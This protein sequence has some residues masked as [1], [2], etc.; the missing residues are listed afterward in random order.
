MIGVGPFGPGACLYRQPDA[1]LPRVFCGRTG[2]DAVHGDQARMN[3]SSPRMSKGVTHMMRRLVSLAAVLTLS[4]VLTARAADT[5]ESVEK[6][7]ADQTQKYKSLQYTMHMTGEMSMSGMTNKT[8][9]D[10]QFQALRKGGKVL[11]RMES[12]T[13]S[14]YRMADQPEQ[15]QDVTNLMVNDGELMYTLMDA[16]GQKMARKSKPDPK[17]GGADPLDSAGAFKAMSK[18]FTL[19]LLPE[20]AVDG[21]DAWAIEA[22]PKDTTNPNMPVT[23]M[24]TY[25]DKKTG[26]PVKSLGFGKDGKVVHTMLISDV[27]VNADIPA[28]RFIFKAPEGVEVM[29]MTK[30]AAGSMPATMG[31]DDNQPEPAD[32]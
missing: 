7:I 16:A 21:K 28:D 6:T 23:R 31:L 12:K 8:V 25:Y 32:E 30:V 1:G 26:V 27:K 4:C 5:L 15:T 18:D 17:M 29:D 24:V 22:T 11:S 14:S 20:S 3:V 9:T 2:S 13:H 10:G 19:K